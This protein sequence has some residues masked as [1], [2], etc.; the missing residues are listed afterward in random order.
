M[1]HTCIASDFS[2]NCEVA[3]GVRSIVR[4]GAL[5]FS[6]GCSLVLPIVQFKKCLL[7]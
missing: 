5:A 3:S 7:L 1:Y 6:R 2:S 4:G